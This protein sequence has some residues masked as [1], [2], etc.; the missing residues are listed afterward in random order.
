MKHIQ[1][2][3]VLKPLSLKDVSLSMKVKL[4]FYMQKEEKKR[5]KEKNGP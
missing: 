1:I 4:L 3:E 5:R 2:L